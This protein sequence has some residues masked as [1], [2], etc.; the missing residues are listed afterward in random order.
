M[1][2]VGIDPG[3]AN[4]GL[5]AVKLL[6]P[7][8]IELLAVEL[9]TTKPL[10]RK[11]RLGAADD[12]ARRLTEIEAS[13]RAFLDRWQPTVAAFEDPPWGKTAKA[14]KGCALMWG[15]GHALCGDRGITTVSVSAKE[16][17]KRVVGYEKAS[18]EEVF[19]AIKRLA[20]TYTEWPPATVVEHVA[21]AVG[22]AV[23]ARHHPLVTAL[24]NAIPA[25]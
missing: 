15:A 22:A 19:A 5:A 18:K 20:P 11:L 10:A 12:D 8:G 25:A 9:V 2:L 14:V 6:R 3:F 17:K 4:I 21:D 1:M 13:I 24:L 23:A 16:I 7:A